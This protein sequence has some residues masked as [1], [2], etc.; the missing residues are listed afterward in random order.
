MRFSSALPARQIVTRL[1]SAVALAVGPRSLVPHRVVVSGTTADGLR[2]HLSAAVGRR[3]SFGFGI[4]TARANRKPVLALF[5]D[6]GRPLGFAKVGVDPFTDAQVVREQ[7]SL[8]ELQR[9]RIPGVRTPALLDF[10]TW[11]DHPVLVIGA[12]EPSAWQTARRGMRLPRAQ[13][14]ALGA[15]FGVQEAPL[16]ES[17]WWTALVETARGLPEGDARRDLLDSMDA[18]A[19]GW[20]GRSVR[21]GAW[22]GDWTPWNMGW[23]GGELLLWDFERFELGAPIGLDACHFA[24]SVPSR[25]TDPGEIIR[26]LENAVPCDD[27]ALASW[28][29]AV[30]LVAITCRYQVALQSE[31][32]ALIAPRAALMAHCLT[33][34]LRQTAD[35]GARR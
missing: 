25:T 28:V 30:Y 6:D 26:R 34:W 10:G 14:D 11:D 32:G 33:E 19:S 12:L 15:A 4:G 29:K 16:T 9:V 18:V 24:L 3:V 17:A 2:D 13:M 5:G 8:T 20:A 35:R 31:N 7:Q 1:L 27:P 22:H 21:L 23:S